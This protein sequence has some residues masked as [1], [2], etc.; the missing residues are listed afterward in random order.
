M[1]GK[2]FEPLTSGLWALQATRLLYPAKDFHKQ[3]D[4]GI[5][6]H[7]INLGKVTL[8]HWATS[9]EAFCRIRTDDHR[10]TNTMLY[11]WAKKAHFK[12]SLTINKIDNLHDVK[13]ICQNN[14]VFYSYKLKENVWNYN[15]F[16]TNVNK[17]LNKKLKIKRENIYKWQAQSI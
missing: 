6:T 9:A 2:G 5:R 16:I 14:K 11:L 7:N 8:Y 13:N 12:Y 17:N 3:A 15:K 4:N 10:I 1:A